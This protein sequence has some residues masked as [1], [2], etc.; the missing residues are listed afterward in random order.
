M[1]MMWSRAPNAPNTGQPSSR[2]HL[3]E[4]AWLVRRHLPFPAGSSAIPDHGSGDVFVGGEHERMTAGLAVTGNRHARQ[5][6]VGMIGQHRQHLPQIRSTGD[7]AEVVAAGAGAERGGIGVLEE[8]VR[9][10]RQEAIAG[11]AHS[12]IAGMGDE[13]VALV[14]QDDDGDAAFD[15]LG[16]C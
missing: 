10:N 2:D 3:L 15:V 12:E 1:E 8:E 7:V 4:R 16:C 9:S 11:A 14:H 6:G 13:A 5:V